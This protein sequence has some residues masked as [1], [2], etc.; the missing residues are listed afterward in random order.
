MPSI[1][2]QLMDKGLAAG[3]PPF[4]RTNVHYETIMGSHAYG[5]ADT[6]V[7]DKLPD[8]DVYG[9]AIPPK[10]YIFPQLYG[11]I[12]SFGEKPGSIVSFGT[13]RKGFEQWQKHR[14]REEPEG[15]PDGVTH[16]MVIAELK[17]RGE[18]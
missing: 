6:S 15:V 3:A 9:F 2:Q 1:T 12:L 16:E 18:I 4:L 10:E 5:V 7:K 11:K 17:K 13:D 14:I 8:Y